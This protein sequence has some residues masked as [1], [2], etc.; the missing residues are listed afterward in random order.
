MCTLDP[1]HEHRSSSV[2]HAVNHFAVPLCM[3]QVRYNKSFSENVTVTLAQSITAQTA[4]GGE[5]VVA[6][7]RPPPLPPPPAYNVSP[8]RVRH[9]TEMSNETEQRGDV[10]RGGGPAPGPGLGLGLGLGLGSGP[11]PGLRVD[12]RYLQLRWTAGVLCSPPV[13]VRC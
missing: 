8:C 13:L 3:S 5:G 12:R 4:E 10:V 1:L 11:G 7:H 6:V 2:L 9:E